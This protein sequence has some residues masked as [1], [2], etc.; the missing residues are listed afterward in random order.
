MSVVFEV[1]CFGILDIYEDSDDQ[2]QAEIEKL[3]Q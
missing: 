2:Y 1:I 3:Q